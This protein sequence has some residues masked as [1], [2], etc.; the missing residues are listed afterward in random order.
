M[1]IL[2]RFE[3]VGW[4]AR[5]PPGGAGT[6][7]AMDDMALERPVGVPESISLVLLGPVWRVLEWSQGVAAPRRALPSD[8]NG[9]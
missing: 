2:V 4:H 9:L 3:V 1:W 5:R 8:R 6:H 7:F